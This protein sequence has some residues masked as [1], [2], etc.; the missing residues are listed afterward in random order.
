MSFSKRIKQ[1][2]DHKN[3]GVRMFEKTCG[4]NIGT[5]SRVI[6]KDSSIQSD[7][8]EKITTT[9]RELNLE[10]LLTGRGEMLK[11]SNSSNPDNDSQNISS[12]LEWYNEVLER[13]NKE[14]EWQRKQIDLLTSIIKRQTDQEKETE[15]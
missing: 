5:L 9:Y 3:L 1:Y 15:S 11:Y 7:N 4:I 10:W 13:A 8:L 6:V 12:K 2:I 14:I